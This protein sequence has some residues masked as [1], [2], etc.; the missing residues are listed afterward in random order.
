MKAIKIS[1][2]Y[3]V[4]GAVL[5]SLIVL[6]LSFWIFPLFWLSL[7]HSCTEATSS[8]VSN[9]DYFAE[10]IISNCGATSDYATRYNITNIET[11]TK[12]TV[13]SLKGNLAQSCD[14]KWNENDS[15]MISC[16]SKENYVYLK[17]D[18]FESVT[19]QYL[20]NGLLQ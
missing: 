9:R 3:Y 14:M 11:G 10:E 15:L 13:L 16:Q 8:K 12:G 20:L 17:E 7:L 6:C 18:K 4:A 1:K 5:T 2:A 19:V